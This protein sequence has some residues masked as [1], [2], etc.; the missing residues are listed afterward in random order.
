MPREK[1][2]TNTK[3]KTETKKPEVTE[4][5]APAPTPAPAEEETPLVTTLVN[6]SLTVGA[7]YGLFSLAERLFGMI[8]DRFSNSED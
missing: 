5:P 1:K 7:A 6:T 3:P 2:K 8:H 4:V